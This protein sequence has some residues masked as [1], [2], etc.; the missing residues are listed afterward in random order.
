MNVVF[1]NLRE[2]FATPTATITIS[3]D[4]SV[5][6]EGQAGGHADDQGKYV[7]IFYGVFQN[8]GIRD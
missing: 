7:N 4:A 1:R 3:D 6:N 8:F 2:R 5:I